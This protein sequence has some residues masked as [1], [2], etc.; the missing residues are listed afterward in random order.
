[1]PASSSKSAPTTTVLPS[2]ATD[3]PKR[4]FDAASEAVSLATWLYVA[5]SAVR[6]T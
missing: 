2:M 3:L 4:S 6:K 1:M 5:P